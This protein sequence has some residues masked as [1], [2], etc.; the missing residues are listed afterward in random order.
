MERMSVRSASAFL[1]S[2]LST[3]SFFCALGKITRVD[4]P[5]NSWW[6]ALAIHA[7]ATTSASGAL[8]SEP[9]EIAFRGFPIS[10]DTQCGLE[11]RQH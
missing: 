3:T 7:L 2:G 5:N 11:G 10:L 6:Y 8:F 4:L 9:I 1:K